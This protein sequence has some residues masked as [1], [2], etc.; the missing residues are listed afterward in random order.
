MLHQVRDA[1]GTEDDG[2]IALPLANHAPGLLQTVVRGMDASRVHGELMGQV[3]P[4]KGNARFAEQAPEFPVDVPSRPLGALLGGAV[5]IDMD[6]PVYRQA[7][8]GPVQQRLPEL[9]QGPGIVLDRY[10][11]SLFPVLQNALPFQRLL[12]GF[13]PAVHG[14]RSLFS[15]MAA[16]SKGGCRE[17]KANCEKDCYSVENLLE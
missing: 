9:T 12:K 10:Q 13:K 5:H 1:S 7:S 11:G 14:I 8:P 15:V 3:G 6:P 2:G 16:H 4:V 17:S